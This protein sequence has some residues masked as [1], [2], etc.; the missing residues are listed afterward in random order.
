MHRTTRQTMRQQ[1]WLHGHL[2][3]EYGYGMHIK[4]STKKE[5]MRLLLRIL[6]ASRFVM[7][8][9]PL[10]VH[11]MIRQVCSVGCD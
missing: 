1:T 10:D 2:P 8:R 4:N 6:Q 5:H 11:V 3:Y 9:M 7:P